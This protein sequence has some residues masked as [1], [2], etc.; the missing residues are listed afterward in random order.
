[1]NFWDAIQFYFHQVLDFTSITVHLLVVLGFCIILKKKDTSKVEIIKLGLFFVVCFASLVLESCLM[2]AF[3]SVTFRYLFNYN[4]PFVVLLLSVLMIRE[5]PVTKWVKTAVVVSTVCITEVLSKYF[6]VLVGIGTSISFLV[7]LGRIAPTLLYLVVCYLIR[8]FD[9]SHYQT[10]SKEVLLVC[11]ALSFVLILISVFEH[12][13]E[14]HDITICALM[15]SLDVALLL[16]LDIIY[17][18]I[19]SIVENRHKI[20]NLEVQN[21]LVGAERLSISIDQNNREELEKIRHDIKNQLSYISA[22]LQQGKEQEAIH[23]I[24]NYV[25]NQEVLF[26]F[27]CS[28]NVVNS[29]INLELSKAKIYNV[30]MNLKVVI[31]PAFPFEDNDVVSLLTNMI[32]NALENYYK[33]EED[34]GIS[35]CILKQNDYIRFFVSNPIDPSKCNKNNITKTRKSGKRHGYGTK[36]IKNIAD[37]YN[38]FVDFNVEDNHFICDVLLYL[39]LKE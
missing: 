4:L 25:K 38:G 16:I 39:N 29:I 3:S 20:T 30:K 18:T 10:F 37:K 36:I 32:D 5:K 23:Y 1:M 22:L 14:S 19:Y 2:F 27:S 28:N 9:I 24:D 17:V 33:G 12:I 31:P 11:Y 15:S 7:S 8:K 6:G 34:P 26:S 13:Y 35:V 21:T